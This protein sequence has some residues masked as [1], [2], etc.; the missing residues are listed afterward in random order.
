MGPV[1]VT[2]E[3]IGLIRHQVFLCLCVPG[4]RIFPLACIPLNLRRALVFQN[5]LF[6][7]TFPRQGQALPPFP[8]S[9]SK[10]W[11][12]KVVEVPNLIKVLEP[13]ENQMKALD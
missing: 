1:W 13:F 4:P 5:S 8:F 7:N 11:N 9:F 10:D 6:K 12:L 3:T 2:G